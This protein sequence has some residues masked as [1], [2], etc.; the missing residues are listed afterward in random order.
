MATVTLKGSPIQVAGELPKKGDKA[1]DFA[2]TKTDM[3][4][5]SR[6]SFKGQR[7]ILNIFPSV[8]TSVCAMSVREFNEKAS[9][10]S[11]TTVLC[12]S[13]DLPFA[14][15]RFCAAEGLEKVVPVSDFRTGDFAKNYGTLMT[16][17]PLAGLHARSVVV[18]DENGTVIHSELVPEIAQ[19]PNYEA[20]LA[21]LK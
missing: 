1:S 19:E 16:D 2:L 21:V 12:I 17:G 3:S 13:K 7:L 15:N 8:D 6:E 20:A 11:N 18:L 9:E 5:V 14:L 4:T 10:V